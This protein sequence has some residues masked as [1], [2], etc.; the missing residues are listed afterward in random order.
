[1]KPKI[2]SDGANVLT[3]K[4]SNISSGWEQWFLLSADRHHDNIYCDRELEKKHLD[5]AKERNAYILDFGDLFCA[6][7]GKYD[8]RKSMDDIRP[9]DVGADYLDRIVRHAAEDYAPYAKQFLL[10]GKGN[11]ESAVLKHNSTCLISQL[12]YQLNQEFGGSVH[13]GGYAGWVKFKF[14]VHKTSQKSMNLKYHH[15][16]G[17]GGPVTRGVIQTNRQAVYLPDAD[18]VVNGHTHDS[19]VLPL[20]RERLSEQGVVGRDLLWFV[21]TPGYKNEYADGSGGFIVERWGPPKPI[22]ATWLRF[23]YDSNDLIR[24]ECTQAVT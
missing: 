5:Q 1:M 9:E 11:H 18:I 21:R 13:I 17:G 12:C 22:G 20:A 15:G 19:W 7:Q 3:V 24:S 23:Y 14:V 6:M 8:P 2:T 4:F 10:I 16:A